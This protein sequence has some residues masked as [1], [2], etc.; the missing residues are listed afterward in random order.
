M[1]KQHCEIILASNSLARKSIM[2]D[3]G[4]IYQSISPKFNEDTEKYNINLSSKNLALYLATKKAMSLANDYYNSYIIGS[5]QLC[6][7]E[8]NEIFKPNNNNNAVSQLKKLRN[9]THAQNNAIVIIYQNKIVFKNI[10]TAKLT[11]HNLSDSEIANYVKYDNPVGCAG[12]YKFESQGKY[13]FSQVSGSY[14]AIL[15]L[16]IVPILSFFYKN[17][18]INL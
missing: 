10:S 18:L 9:K 16:D 13:L 4:L 8:N 5:D 15:G 17:K 1:I 6:L 7:L 2:D 3:T 11:M 14:H 12:S